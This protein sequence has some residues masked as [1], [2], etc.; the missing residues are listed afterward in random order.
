MSAAESKRLRLTIT[1]AEEAIQLAANHRSA[2][3]APGETIVE[4]SERWN[5]ATE[6]ETTAKAARKAARSA[7][8]GLHTFRDLWSAEDIAGKIEAARSAALALK[9]ACDAAQRAQNARAFRGAARDLKRAISEAADLA[10]R[11][12]KGGAL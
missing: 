1:L 2:Q 9:A 5:E 6:I 11:R 4:T 12:K 7:L 8:L 10:E 3:H